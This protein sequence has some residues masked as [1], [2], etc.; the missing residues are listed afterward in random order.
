[1][2]DPQP[3]TA[4]RPREFEPSAAAESAL[5]TFWA[6]G[7]HDVSV[8]EL[9][10]ATGVV[11][12]SL[13]NTFGNKRGVFDAAL[14]TY[15]G[16]LFAEIDSMLT[17]ASGG[18]GDIHAFLDQLERWHTSGIPGCFMIN[19]M[20]EFADR[21]L[22]I[23]RRG[24]NY[25]DKLR[26]AF[27]AALARAEADDELLGDTNLDRT[28][29][30]LLLETIGLNMAARTGVDTERLRQLYNAAHDTVDLLSAAAQEATKR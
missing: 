19:S 4:G 18:L 30:R 2:T 14:D 5:E 17:D 13:Y 26:A 25:L 16:R 27:H 23:N 28:A 3:R 15:L 8:S 29:D 1:M 12:T 11:R 20:I 21:D 10:K 9:E 6:N 7:F 24:A 22:D